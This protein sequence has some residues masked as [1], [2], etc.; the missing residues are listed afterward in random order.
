M[1][2]GVPYRDLGA[3]DV[4]A[5]TEAVKA[6]PDEAWTRNTFR[7]DALADPAHTATMALIFKHEYDPRYNSANFKYME[8]LVEVWARN[9]GLPA[10]DYRPIAREETDLG[11]VYTFPEWRDWEAL[12]RPILDQALERLGRTE[13]GVVTRL[14]LV[15]LK[16]NGKINPHIDGQPMAAVAHRLHV[17]VVVPPGVEYRIG[18]AKFTMKP[19]H[20][21]D[22]NNRMLHSVKHTGKRPRV[23]LFIDYYPN[24][25]IPRAAPFG[26]F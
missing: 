26:H 13:R 9:K 14:A 20:L 4:S 16:P 23:N 18:P 6:M 19:G 22:F 8:D 1:D 11:F 17:P 5:L 21:Y 25:G 10:D 12:L 3:L 2:I 15:K 24:P 7:Q